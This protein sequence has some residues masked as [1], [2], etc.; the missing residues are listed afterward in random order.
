M[1]GFQQGEIWKIRRP[2]NW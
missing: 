2:K 1:A